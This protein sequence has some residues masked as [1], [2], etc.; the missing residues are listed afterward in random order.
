MGYRHSFLIR[1]TYVFSLCRLHFQLMPCVFV[2]RLHRKST[3]RIETILD[4]APY[5]DE[6]N[7][8]Y[9]VYSR[10]TTL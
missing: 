6:V 3:D 2:S 1:C 7:F 9:R 8:A 4:S 10:S 5:T